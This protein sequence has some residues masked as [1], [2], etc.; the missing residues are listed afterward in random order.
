MAPGPVC[1]P[2]MHQS[3][4]A[5]TAEIITSKPNIDIHF[6]MPFFFPLNTRLQLFHLK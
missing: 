6:I 4:V 1:M 2:F 5:I 3:I